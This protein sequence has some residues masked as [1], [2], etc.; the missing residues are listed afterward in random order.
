M[1]ARA[2]AGT[3]RGRTAL[4]CAVVLAATLGLTQL[5][6]PGAPGGGRGTPAAILFRGLVAGLIVSLQAVGLVV[7]YRTLRIVNFA[8]LGLGVPAAVL[9][10]QFMQYTA[11][12][13]PI[14]FVL[15]LVLSGLLGAT[16]G[17]VLLRF[18]NSSRLF[19]T[20]VTIVAVGLLGL[21]SAVV[22]RL[23]FFPPLEERT[24]AEMAPDIARLL[25]FGGFSFQVG[26]FPLNFGFPH[27]FAIE[28][29]VLALLGVVAFLRFTRTGVA[30][31]AL[32]ENP[33]RAA[34]LGIA[35][36]GLSVVVW[37]LT[38]LLSGASAMLAAGAPVPTP[39][40]PFGPLF[41]A[42]I[43]AVIARM[44]SIPVTVYA[45]VLLGIVQQAWVF[46]LSRD[47]ELFNVLLFVLVAAALL[48]QRRRLGRSELGAQ[49]S[50]SA[51][52]EP[53][54]VPKELAGITGLRL[55]RYG[56]VAVGVVA[57][58]VFPF[59][60][61][62]NRVFLGGVI[63]V[64][65]IA[66]LSLVVLTGWAGQVSLGQF[67]LVAVGSVVGG[68]LTARAGLSFWLAVPVAVAVTAAFAV[69]VGLPALR[70]KGLFLLVS[71]FGF[72]VAVEA[73]LFQERYFGWLLPTE[74]RRPTLF[75]LDF[76]DERSMY[77][78]CLVALAL[79]LAVVANL[80][81]SHV[82]RV[83]IALRENEPNVQALGIHA[84]R[85]K[86]LAFAVSGALAG[87]AGVVFAHQQRGVSRASFL[88]GA[89]VEV[90]VQAVVG[91]V[92]S[93]GGALL[94]SAY[95]Q[96]VR[97]FGAANLIVAIFF[98]G[99]GPLLVLFL[100][101]GGLIG[102]VNAARDSVLRIVAQRRRIVVPSLFADYDPETLAR[103]LIPLAE[104]D[105]SSALAALPPDRRFSLTSELYQGRGER[106]VDRL[107]PRRVDEEAAALD[108]AARKVL[109]LE[110]VEAS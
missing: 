31:R 1:V 83:L 109:D 98:A 96:L 81:R 39:G 49:V 68:A 9:L 85:T 89:S 106:I 23:P 43:P 40:G 19:L 4:L 62:T 79:A 10:V 65:A 47:P 91:G 26:S 25:P 46:S 41:L 18:F 50:W 51:T 22:I 88:A 21:A 87:F 95:F 11:V 71:T 58:V 90:F 15:G 99:L 59:L 30:V 53:R 70:I 29:A 77:F 17:V 28:V 97:E 56:L 37:V 104:A 67:G 32:A 14:A 75:F 94:G 44:R 36:G 100:V 61:S 93:G 64:N 92:S 73:V 101:P 45:A 8:Q 76:E 78:L 12:P 20:V 80:R 102:V 103:R 34:L 3:D 54:P 24:T 110:P 86:L 60:A 108:A 52:D 35:V 13:F 66:V 16:V 33:E 72:A 74:V 7:V 55:A 27:V 2:A 6:L 82:G 38:S 42:L 107:A 105:G 48:A 63:A 84:V 5:V 69:V 57:V